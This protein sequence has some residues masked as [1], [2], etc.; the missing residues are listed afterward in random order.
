MAAS[1]ARMREVPG[2]ISLVLSEP[3]ALALAKDAALGPFS[4]VPFLVKDLGSIARGLKQSA[5]SAAIGKR[6]EASKTD[7]NL[8]ALFRSA[9][10]MPF[11]LSSVPEVGLALST[12]PEGQ[13][14]ATNPFDSS[15]TPGGS[16]GGAAAAV[17]SG[18]VAIAHAT[19]AAGSIRVP[20]ACC[21]L[22]GLK[23][24]RGVSPM[25]PDYNNW[26]MGIASELVLAR[27]LRDVK[28]AL[29]CVAT[30]DGRMTPRVAVVLP[31][32]CDD[33]QI[34]ATL[35]AAKVLE[36]AGCII[37]DGPP[38]SPS[39]TYLSRPMSLI[40]MI[41]AA[42]LHEGLTATG[43]PDDEL[44]PLLRA[45]R[46]E[47]AALT[48]TDLFGASRDIMQMSDLIL[49]FFDDA[50]AI[51]M[52]V[53]SGPPP[54]L[55]ASPMDHTDLDVHFLKME[56]MA[57][58]AAWANV[59]GLPALAFPA[60]FENGLPVG[61]QLIGRPNTDTALLEFAQPLAHMIDIPFPHPI[62]G[63]PA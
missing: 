31:D 26:L 10:L 57:P 52:P 63:L 51:L 55:G 29:N 2:A 36:A 25:G 35:A 60:G 45:A 50:D 15:R 30:T 24:S 33:T 54:K 56:A 53:L 18:I 34:N 20:A 42:A 61:A 8:I 43:V 28:T 41:L 16:S 7:S 39:D 21:G 47:G 6:I 12:E 48:G 17:A 32:M 27:S 58:N 9:G 4:G 23:P 13:P 22:W 14:P 62:A 38:S 44:P 5:G 46:V 1:L 19:D 49:G 40:R 59:A 37:Q 3:E 11:G